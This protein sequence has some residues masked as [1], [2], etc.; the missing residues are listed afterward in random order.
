LVKYFALK[1][2][3]HFYLSLK[4]FIINSILNKRVKKKKLLLK[5]QSKNLNFTNIEFYVKQI[6]IFSE[7]KKKKFLIIFI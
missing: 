3:I 2:I 1:N 4:Y 5:N 7:I 6:L